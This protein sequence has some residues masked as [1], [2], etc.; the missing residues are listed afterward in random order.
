MLLIN[1]IIEFYLYENIIRLVCVY[2]LV[3]FVVF[4]VIWLCYFLMEFL[5]FDILLLIVIG[6][7]MFKF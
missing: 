7:L 5:R 4:Y 1:L 3:V 6:L 2:I